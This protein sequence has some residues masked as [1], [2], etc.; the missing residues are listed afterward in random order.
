MINM[1][2][3]DDDY[4]DGYVDDFNNDDS[5]MVTN[6]YMQIGDDF[7]GVYMY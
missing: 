6:L 1:T 5:L 3:I 7:D 4:D 2:I